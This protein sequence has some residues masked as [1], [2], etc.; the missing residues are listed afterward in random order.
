MSTRPAPA[1]ALTPQL[2]SMA[3]PRLVLTLGARGQSCITLKGAT[4][5]H[6]TNF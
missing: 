5:S 1:Y 2:M 3:A 6:Q 4:K